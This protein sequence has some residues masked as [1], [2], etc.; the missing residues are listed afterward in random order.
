ML[1]MV[2]NIPLE[3]TFLAPSLKNQ[4]EGEKESKKWKEYSCI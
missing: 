3:H 1:D 2:L 4:T